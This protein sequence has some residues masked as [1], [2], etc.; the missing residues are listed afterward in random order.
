MFN[1]AF[2]LLCHCLSNFHIILLKYLLTLDIFS[3]FLLETFVPNLVSL[4]R[5]S[6]QI[7]G[8][9]SPNQGVNSNFQIYGESFINENGHNSRASHDTDM[10]FDPITKLETRPRRKILT[11]TLCQQI[12]MFLSFFNLW[13]ICSHSENRISEVWSE[14]LIF[15]LIVTFHLT[16]PENGTKKTLTQLSYY[17]LE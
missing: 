7:L 3:N 12:L 17:C 5:P 8:I 11:M 10:K 6:L 16:K 13:P 9:N 14:K 15:S 1:F 2:N 4:T